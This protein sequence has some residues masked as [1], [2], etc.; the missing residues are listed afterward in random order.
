MAPGSI[1]SGI[2]RNSVISYYV[3]FRS[4]TTIE[5]SVII[6]DVIVGRH[7]KIKKAI[8][9]KHNVIPSYTEIGYSPKEDA[10]RFTVTPRGIVVVPKGYFT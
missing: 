7:C 4:W 10:K 5:E 2:V 8:I 1:I 3:V 6:D 9:D